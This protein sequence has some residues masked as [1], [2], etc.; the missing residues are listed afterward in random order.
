M[1]DDDF[2]LPQAESYFHPADEDDFNLAGEDHYFPPSDQPAAAFHAVPFTA[3]LLERISFGLDTKTLL[4]AQ[5]VCTFWR[6][7]IQ[8]SP[9]LQR[10]LSFQSDLLWDTRFVPASDGSSITSDISSF[11]IDPTSN[12][13]PLLQPI[14]N[15]ILDPNLTSN[16]QTIHPPHKTTNTSS[17]RN[18][19]SLTQPPLTGL[20]IIY[21]SQHIEGTSFLT[22]RPRHHGRR[23]G[24]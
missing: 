19:M 5:R 2:D 3:E 20:F 4:L 23:C 13:E 8:A 22:K 14:R 17:W 6:N 9:L 11:N 15:P 16:T 12:R 24:G 1:A 18:Y 10:S 21:G 7:T